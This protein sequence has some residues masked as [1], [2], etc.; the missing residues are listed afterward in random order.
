MPTRRLILAAFTALLALPAVAHG[1]ESAVPTA[2]QTAY[3]LDWAPFIDPADLPPVSQRKVVCLVDS[4]VAITE[5]LPADRPEGPIVQRVSTD[6]GSGLPGTLFEEQQHG[7]KMASFAG[8]VMGNDWGTVGAWP[9]VRIL[10]VRAMSHARSSFTADEIRMAMEKCSQRDLPVVA[11][12]LSLGGEYA[13]TPAHRAVLAEH[14]ARAREE[15][16]SV[17]GAAGNRGRSELEVPASIPGVTAIAA[18]DAGGALCSYAT[19][20]AD[21]LIGPGCGVDVEW[22]GLPART[23][24]GGSSAATMFG[25]TT[26][27]LL[28]S[29]YL[30]KF[31][32]DASRQDAERWLRDAVTA[33]GNP[34][35]N[36]ERAARAAGL[37]DVVDRA[38]ARA[39]TAQ[40]YPVIA[41]PPTVAPRPAAD[42]DATAQN[43]PAPALPRRVP[44]PE[45]AVAWKR[46]KIL[47]R[48]AS[49]SDYAERLRVS[50]TG[51]VRAARMTK[52]VTIGRRR[53][54]TMRVGRRPRSVALRLLP[55]DGDVIAPSATVTL[56][57][58]PGGGY[59]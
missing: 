20:V 3:G 39:T 11:I 59:R 41:S 55:Y 32:V 34:V 24:G 29:L 52:T 27:A 36:V 14:V 42:H 16:M 23:D 43:V 5:D 48:L 28:R 12:N 58:R 2:Q 49:R 10:S 6:G 53:T 21:V 31:G 50:T 56:E 4:G 19:Y 35:I 18:G 51:P 15:G 17:L 22:A 30:R 1:A 44:R 40:P 8:A 38:R 13:I 25:S 45:A 46:G 47:V 7:T 33:T 54:V 9:G 57:A 26:V 37:G